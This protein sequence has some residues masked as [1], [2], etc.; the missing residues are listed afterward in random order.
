ML[1]VNSTVNIILRRDEEVDCLAVV[2]DF[3]CGPGT[4]NVGTQ[5]VRAC[6]VQ[7]CPRR[8]LQF[9][10]IGQNPLA[11]QSGRHLKPR[12][13]QQMGAHVLEGLNRCRIDRIGG[14]LGKIRRWGL[15]RGRVR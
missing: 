3:A 14:G 15:R 10:A 5:P 11:G 13:G 9:L 1:S 12:Q 8:M 2:E 4:G 6:N 7:L